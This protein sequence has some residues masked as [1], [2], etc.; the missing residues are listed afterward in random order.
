M[1][2]VRV[3]QQNNSQKLTENLQKIVDDY[4]IEV[5]GSKKFALWLYVYTLVKGEFRE[6]WIP[7]NLF[8]RLVSPE[9]NK[10]LR[11]VPGFKTFSN[12]VL[13]TEVLPDLGCYIDGVFY[14]KNF[15]I[16]I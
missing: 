2:A 16:T 11:V 10:I 6:G 14:I 5:L 13:E 8:G 3:I 12:V 9:I 4:S 1:E 15:S 7:D